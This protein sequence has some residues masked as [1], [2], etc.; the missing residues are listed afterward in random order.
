MKILSEIALY[1]SMFDVSYK[2]TENILSL[3]EERGFS[4]VK[5]MLNCHEVEGI[6]S[7][8]EYHKMLKDESF[9]SFIKNLKN[10]G[11]E[12][13]TKFDENYPTSLVGLPEQPIVLYLKGDLSL[14]E[15]SALAVVGTREPSNYGRLI[16][17]NFVKELVR[18]DITIVSG[19]AYGV[20]AIS[21]RTTLQEKG[22]T[23]AVLGCGF[24]EIYPSAHTTLAK[25]IAEC[26]LLVSEYPPFT[27]ATK[28]TFPRRNRIITGLSKGILITEA[29][30]K[31]GTIHTKEYALEYGRDVFAVPGNINSPKSYLPNM[32]IKSAQ[33]ECVLS[34][35]DILKYYGIDAKSAKS[36]RKSNSTLAV[37]IEEEIILQ[38]LKDGEQDF[39]HLQ[40]K[41]KIPVNILNSCLTTLEIRGL[42]KKMPAKT[43]IKI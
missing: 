25:E 19:L 3:A 43:Y 36:E 41:S 39:E 17:E 34:P 4:S 30:N 14:L 1:L 20:D 35:E 24:N 15:T 21:H 23:I 28:Y 2:K 9:P 42:I 37:S 27:K 5:D 18:A 32:L 11:I 31:S 8:E 38:L 12:V 29:G 13:I 33:A 10:D 7:A 26:G 40:E 6:L 22:K 16:T